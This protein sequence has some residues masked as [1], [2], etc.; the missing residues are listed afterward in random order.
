[1]RRAVT[2][3]S[4]RPKTYVTNVAGIRKLP[5]RMTAGIRL[6]LP[7]RK[8]ITT[9]ANQSASP[10]AKIRSQLGHDRRLPGAVAISGTGFAIC[11]VMSASLAA[12]AGDD[13]WVG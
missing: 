13:P 7:V 1:M 11:W 3:S 9:V 10:P 2:T 6:A 5:S 12:A 8:V 4:A